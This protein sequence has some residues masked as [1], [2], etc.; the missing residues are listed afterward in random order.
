VHE[1]SVCQ[2]LLR[3]VAR[4]AAE[5]DAVAVDRIVLQVGG[6]SGVEPPLL[7]RAFEVARAGTLAEAAEL[8]IRAGPVVVLCRECGSRGEVPVNRLL[9]PGCGDWRVEVV[10]GEELLLLTIDMETV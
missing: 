7:E 4:M 8:E 3:E 10:E 9:C 5:H 6:L 1:L 2:G